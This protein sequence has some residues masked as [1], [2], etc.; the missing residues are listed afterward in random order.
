MKK[1]DYKWFY[2]EDSLDKESHDLLFDDIK[3]KSKFGILI[4]SD[5]TV[6]NND[7]TII[8]NRY[9]DNTILKEIV[10]TALRK[11]IEVNESH[12][13]ECGVKVPVLFNFG[14]LVNPHPTP[15]MKSYGWHKDF[16]LIDIQ[17]PLKLWFSMLMLSDHDVDS[18]FLVS[19]TPEGPGFWNIGV[20]TKATSN[21]LFGH[22]MNLGHG[23]FPGENN[24]VYV[25]YMRW[26]DAG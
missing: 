3:Q 22:N 18:E 5:G 23:F 21:K 11:M 19:P 13:L 4:N 9:H 26:F 14:V 12:L 25:L 6:I 1:S 17:D 10:S 2:K 20:R 24:Q 7:T 15:D 8:A 16:N